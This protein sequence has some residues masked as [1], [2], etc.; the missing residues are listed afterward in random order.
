MLQRL[1][2]PCAVARKLQW[3]GEFPEVQ[4]MQPGDLF[5][6]RPSGYARWPKEVMDAWL[7]LDLDKIVEG[8]RKRSASEAF[9]V[10][11]GEPAD[12]ALPGVP[13]ASE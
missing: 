13:E 7:D 2:I 12:A 11:D 10:C 1:H 9:A 3:E 8:A 4:A 6:F 5:M